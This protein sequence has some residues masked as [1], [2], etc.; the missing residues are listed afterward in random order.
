[1]SRSD[2]EQKER[3][4][5]ERCRYGHEFTPENTRIHNGNG[6]RMCR[7]CDRARRRRVGPWCR[8]S[9]GDGN[10]RESIPLTGDHQK[11]A[12]EAMKFSE[13]VIR[14]YERIYGNRLEF[15]GEAYMRIV[16]R[17][18]TY[19]PD[20]ASLDEWARFKACTACRD[21]L[22]ASRRSP[23]VSLDRLHGLPKEECD[24]VIGDAE[25]DRHD[26][27]GECDSRD[28]VEF[29]LSFASEKQR[30][31]IWRIDILGET[32]REAAEH[33]GVNPQS[34]WERRQTGLAAIRKAI[35]DRR[36]I[37]ETAT[38]AEAC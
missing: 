8:K 36:R 19:N 13:P 15:R 24:A 6:S 5:Q 16:L 18:A 34:V 35:E 4:K 10:Q 14:K 29:L 28:E 22:K 25:C 20:L 31:A 32:C 37:R 26:H 38:Q 11:I 9:N 27:V 7:T 17:A 21:V 23:A 30:G 12:E 3:K 1:M 2:G 33:L